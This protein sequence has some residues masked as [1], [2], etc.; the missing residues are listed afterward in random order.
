[1][2][3]A[4]R[5]FLF[6][7]DGAHVGTGLLE[8]KKGL[9][10]FDEVAARGFMSEETID[11]FLR[12]AGVQTVPA[13][14]VG[15][16]VDQSKHKMTHF[17]STPPSGLDTPA[18]LSP[19]SSIDNSSLECKPRSSSSARSSQLPTGAVA[20]K[21]R[22]EQPAT[23]K[24][25]SSTSLTPRIATSIKLPRVVIPPAASSRNAHTRTK[26]A[27]GAVSSNAAKENIGFKELLQAG[28]NN[29]STDAIKRARGLEA[30]TA[31]KQQP[32]CLRH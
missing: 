11:K 25:A 6:F 31:A 29:S 5:Q 9:R 23:R 8:D 13:P 20:S 4:M 22:P 16:S 30:D 24:T 19:A 21:A 7:D 17:A 26:A 10:T 28:R 15:A 14:S 3:D 12:W 27:K 18:S 2:L 32:K 1:M